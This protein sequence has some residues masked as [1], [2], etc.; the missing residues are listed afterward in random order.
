[1]MVSSYYVVKS[2][3]YST[4]WDDSSPFPN[5]KL[6]NEEWVSIK[7]GLVKNN[8][9]AADLTTIDQ[10]KPIRKELFSNT[11]S[12]PIEK[13]KE[14]SFNDSISNKCLKSIYTL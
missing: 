6:Y 8:D 11:D 3:P 14:N 2:D 9:K 7:Q 5:K 12:N 4:P 13:Q 1:M 10:A